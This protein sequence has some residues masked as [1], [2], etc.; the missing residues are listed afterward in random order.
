MSAFLIE[1]RKKLHKN[2]WKP[3]SYEKSKYEYK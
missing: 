2:G 3:S 1:E